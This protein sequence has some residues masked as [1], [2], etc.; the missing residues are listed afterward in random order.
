M[1]YTTLLLLLLPM[2][3]VIIEE[4]QMQKDW[5]VFHAHHDANY[6]HLTDLKRKS[7]IGFDRFIN[8][9]IYFTCNRTHCL[10]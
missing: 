3:A 1:K 7:E 6:V 5:L 10:R 4:N 2:V 9:E 8:I